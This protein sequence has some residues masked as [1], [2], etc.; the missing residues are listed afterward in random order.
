MRLGNEVNGVILLAPKERP[1]LDTVAV[2][3]LCDELGPH[4]A[5]D[6]M[7]RA[8]EELSLRLCQMHDLAG[9]GTVEDLH[10]SLRGLAAIA[11]Q[12]GLRVLAR[13][14]RDAMTCIEMGDPVAQAATLARL[15]RVGEGALTALCDLQDMPG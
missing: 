6:M 14:A 8:M 1:Q 7:C 12:I 13:V 4:M 3:A 11:E 10:K 15:S 9:S 5:E 2:Q